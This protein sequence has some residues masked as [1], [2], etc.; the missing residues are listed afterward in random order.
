MT[1]TGAPVAATA[2]TTRS[3]SAVV[4]PAFSAASTAAWTTGPSIT[5]SL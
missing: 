2:S 3:T 5:G 1:T 4:V